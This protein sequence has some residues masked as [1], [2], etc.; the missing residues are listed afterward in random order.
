MDA[1]DPDRARTS[2]S[3]PGALV[4]P[5]DDASWISFH[6]FLNSGLNLLLD[7]VVRPAVQTLLAERRI[8]RFFFIRYAEQGD[9]IR[10]RLRTRQRDI[11]PLEHHAHALLASL[12]ERP[13]SALHGERPRI[14]RAALELEVE[15]YGGERLLPHSLDHFAISS[16]DALAL[17]AEAISMTRAQLLPRSM[18]RLVQQA[19]GL[20]IDLVDFSA[21]LDYFVGW[22]PRMA[23]PMARADAVFD[24][25]REAFQRQFRSTLEMLLAG[26]VPLEVQAAQ[27]LSRTVQ[28][29][30]L[31]PRRILT[32][33]QLHMSS[34][35][36]G[37]ANAEEGY[38]TRLMC[39]CA[40]A[41]A[42]RDPAFWSEVGTCL[43]QQR[44]QEAALPGETLAALVSEQLQRFCITAMA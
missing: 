31:E 2:D 1:V 35:R 27:C 7:Q 11:G 33:S 16:L 23:L 22:R 12:A 36:M 4:V 21:L 25:N 15:R 20:A 6:L 28:D 40:V 17:N 19:F 29:L 10:L 30:P 41:L 9:H 39:R 8:D 44:T 18:T 34:N 38:L 5:L 14:M 43:L 42:E 26:K 37:L 3:G 24:A 32:A 13:A